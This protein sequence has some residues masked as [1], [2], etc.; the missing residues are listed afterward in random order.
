[1]SR[2]QHKS[3]NPRHF[4]SSNENSSIDDSSLEEKIFTKGDKK[5]NHSV[6]LAGIENDIETLLINPDVRIVDLEGTSKEKFQRVRLTAQMLYDTEWYKCFFDRLYKHCVLIKKP[7]PGTVGGY[8]CGCLASKNFPESSCTPTCA[9]G[10]SF[11]KDTEGWKQCNKVV[12]SAVYNNQTNEYD[13]NIIKEA[14]NASEYDPTYIY[15]DSEDIHTFKGFNY[16]E[17]SF[18]ENKGINNVKMFGTK[19]TDTGITHPS[20]YPDTIAT[21]NIKMRNS[22]TN[23]N[24]NSGFS[25]AALIIFIILLLILIFWLCRR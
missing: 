13:F 18:L 14:Q 10:I 20:L 4:K 17:I 3:F 6:D 19:V 21:D 23:N 25:V 8:L 16:K 15:V 24:S 2:I 9:N 1:M 7:L 5:N 11:P 12:I 22:N